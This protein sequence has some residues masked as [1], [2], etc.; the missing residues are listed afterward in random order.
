L[1]DFRRYLSISA[2]CFAV[3]KSAADILRTSQLAS[4]VTPLHPLDGGGSMPAGIG[5]EKFQEFRF[6]VLVHTLKT[7]KQ[8]SVSQTALAAPSVKNK[9]VPMA[10]SA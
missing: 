6:E 4:V 8:Y 1:L 9:S 5:S 2:R 7:P 3:S 10:S